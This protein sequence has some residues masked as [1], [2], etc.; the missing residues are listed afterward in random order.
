MCTIKLRGNVFPVEEGGK[1]SWPFSRALYIVCSP[2]DSTTRKIQP[3]CLDY[4][5]VELSI[6][7]HLLGGL[8]DVFLSVPC[9]A[10]SMDASCA[11]LLLSY[12]MQNPTQKSWK[13]CTIWLVCVVIDLRTI[14]YLLCLDIPMHQFCLRSVLPDQCDEALTQ[15]SLMLRVWIPKPQGVDAPKIALVFR[16]YRSRR[17]TTR[18]GIDAVS[19]VRVLF[20]EL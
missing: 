7:Q 6:L 2:F 14:L 16:R 18:I 19:A 3:Y 11:R 5:S 9:I 12:L 1:T 4:I 8:M 10:P 17:S 20:T 15:K 13:T